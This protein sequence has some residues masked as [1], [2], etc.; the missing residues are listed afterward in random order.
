MTTACAT[1][2]TERR[3]PRARGDARRVA[4]AVAVALLLAAGA[5]A[6]GGQATGPPANPAPGASAAPAAPLPA[7]APAAGPLLTPAELRDQFDK[8]NKALGKA[9]KATDGH[10]PGRVALLLKTADDHI[11][12][13]EAGSGIEAFVGSLAAARTAA[14]TGDFPAAGA[15]LRRG[16]ESLRSLA[17]YTVARPA[18]VAYR[19]ALAAL[20]DR[21]PEDFEAALGRLEATVRAPYIADRLH[22]ARAA[23]ARGRS[24]MVRN[25]MKTGRK[26]VTAARAALGR[27]DYAGSL[28]QARHCLL[29]EADLLR[30]S[31]FITAREQAQ[32]ALRAVREA[33]ERA[34]DADVDVLDAAE[35]AAT[36]VWRRLAKPEPGDPERLEAVADR[37]ETLR[38]RLR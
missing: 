23:I 28:G 16:R 17:D 6:R 1:S 4:R 29:L 27:V 26:E 13:F 7:A 11:V 24:A 2:D 14:A 18:E 33:R 21:K 12:S 9:E 22:D 30:Q 25:D 31:S 32:Q 5:P 3:R 35:A 36:E 10:D 15:A 38:D 8:C 34:P 37:I 19:A 20:D